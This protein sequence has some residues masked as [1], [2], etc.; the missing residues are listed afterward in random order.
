MTQDVEDDDAR[1]WIYQNAQERREVND[2]Y[3][4]LMSRVLQRMAEQMKSGDSK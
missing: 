1:S 3:N 4:Q 2:Q